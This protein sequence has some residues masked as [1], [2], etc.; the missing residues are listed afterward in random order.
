MEIEIDSNID[1]KVKDPGCEPIA[2]VPHMDLFELDDD[3][4][5]DAF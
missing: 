1:C 4:I 2:F 5:I 3:S